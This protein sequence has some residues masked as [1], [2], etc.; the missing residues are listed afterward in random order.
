LH[1]KDV[2]ANLSK[3]PWEPGSVLIWILARRDS[4]ATWRRSHTRWKRDGERDVQR[5]NGLGGE[6]SRCSI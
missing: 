5:A 1:P 6:L 3:P 2:V 4:A